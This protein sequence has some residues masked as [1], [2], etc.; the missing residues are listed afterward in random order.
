MAIKRLPSTGDAPRTTGVPESLVSG[1]AS[2]SAGFPWAGRTFDHHETAFADDDGA[3]PEEFGIAVDAVRAAAAALRGAVDAE[4]QRVALGDLADAHAGAIL[5]LSQCRVLVPLVAEAGDFGETDDGRTVEKSQELSI[6]TVLGP[7]GR[8]VMPVFSSVATLRAWNSEARPIPVAA[9]QAALAAA[10]DDHALIIVD[11][12]TPEREFGVRRTAL[13][14]LAAGE[15]REPAWADPEVERAF[16]SGVTADSQVRYTAIVPGDPE[17]RLLAPEV[18][19]V[20][21]LEPALDRE[22]LQAVLER[23]SRAWAEHPIIAERVDSLR[24]VPT[25]SAS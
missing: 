18:E 6:V 5:A 2:D 24:V 8:R 3:T 9:P 7:D 4:G 16:A 17:A 14:A 21:G 12:G 23:A 22:T 1:G 10:Q 19:V 25:G 20:L 15:R 13:Q 11:P